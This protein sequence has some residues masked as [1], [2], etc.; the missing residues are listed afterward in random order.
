MHEKTQADY[1]FAVGAGLVIVL[2][3]ELIRWLVGA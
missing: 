2:I 3:A 1:W